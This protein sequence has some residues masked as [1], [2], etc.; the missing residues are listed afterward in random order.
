VGAPLTA[1]KYA[2]IGFFFYPLLDAQDDSIIVVAAAVATASADTGGGRSNVCHG[3]SIVS[4]VTD[5][6]IL[7]SKFA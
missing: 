4:D 5:H 7:L 3:A 1:Y 6:W 2:Q